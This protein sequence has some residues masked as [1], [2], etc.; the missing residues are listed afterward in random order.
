[1][2]KNQFEFQ[3]V[4]DW[5]ENPNEKRISFSVE[6]RRQPTEKPAR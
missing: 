3:Y 1:M 2:V 4:Y 5:D 6:T